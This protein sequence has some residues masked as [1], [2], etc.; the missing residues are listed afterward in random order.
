VEEYGRLLAVT[1][2][3]ARLHAYLE[4]QG[5]PEAERA[6][7]VPRL[8]RRKTE[9]FLD[10]VADGAVEPRPGVRE[11]L[12][13]VAAGG[14]RLAVATT[15]SLAWVEPLLER[16]FGLDRFEVVVGGDDVKAT[17]PD[18]AAYLITLERLAL[19]PAEAVAVE[20]SVPGLGAARAAGVPC[21][22]VVNDYTRG[23]D[24]SGAALVVDGFGDLD[25][26][27]L[28]SLAEPSIG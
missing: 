16:H 27:C 9:V 26:A 8:H 12:D 13:G 19:G 20:D 17:K 23:Q 22:V 14:L 10:L 25:V 18:P 21:V 11:F 1:G 2:G 7:L 6:D 28:R 3:Q 4:E 15:G 24:F 5:V